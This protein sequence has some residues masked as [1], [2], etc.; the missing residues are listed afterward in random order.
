MKAVILQSGYLPWLGY[1]DLINQANIFIFLDDVQWTTGTW[2]NRNRI[3]VTDGW[4]WLTVPVLFEKSHL[5]YQIKDVKVNYTHKW[6]RK[7]VNSLWTY[8]KKAQFFDEVYPFIENILNKKHEFVVD[9]SYELILSICEYIG[10]QDT[11]FMFSQDMNISPE[12]HKTDRL[13]EIFDKVGGITTYIS[14][15]AAKAYLDEDKLNEVGIK[16]IWQDYNHPYYNQNMWGNNVF[17][18]YLSVIDLLFNHGKESL[19]IL[20]NDKVITKPED[21]AIVLPEDYEREH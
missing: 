4:L 1:F 16:V 11:V 5:E 18:P 21:V 17:I 8:Y 15:Q 2:R 12:L 20:S 14:G 6:Q 7:H 13:I 3:R 9:L 19:D 10:I